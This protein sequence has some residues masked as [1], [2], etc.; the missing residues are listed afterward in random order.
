MKPKP[1]IQGAR[2]RF[3]VTLIVGIKCIDSVTLASDSQVTYGTNKRLDAAKMEDVWFGKIPVLIA[4][5]GSVLHSNRFV[6]LLKI[7]AATTATSTASDIGAAA[8]SA[9]RK[10][11]MEIRETRFGITA[12]ELSTYLMNEGIQVGIMLGFFLG[13]TPYIFTVDLDRA[14]AHESR[15]NYEALGCGADLGGYLLSEH[16]SPIMDSV[17]AAGVAVYVVEQVKMRD[18]ACGGDTKVSL[19]KIS[20][21]G[22]SSIG[23]Y[24]QSG[25]NECARRFAAVWQQGRGKRIQEFHSAMMNDK[26]RLIET[27]KADAR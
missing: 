24:D 7:E 6:D 17:V 16:V 18:A 13:V 1:L 22:V 26:F 12:D 21:E 20:D 9:M 14:I 4:Q 3:P 5:S 8:Q 15:F 27:L 23:R 25:V 11:R 2:R 10:L 19:I